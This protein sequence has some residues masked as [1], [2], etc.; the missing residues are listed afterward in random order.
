MCLGGLH[1]DENLLAPGP[2][3]FPGCSV[4]HVTYGPRHSTGPAGL[5]C[6]GPW[7][8]ELGGT[9]L[10][11]R[12][13]TGSLPSAPGPAPRKGAWLGAPSVP[14]SP[15]KLGAGR[16]DE[17]PCHPISLSPKSQQGPS[18]S[19]GGP[20]GQRRSSPS[21]TPGSGPSRACGDCGRNSV[22]RGGS[23]SRLQVRRGVCS[24]QRGRG[25][26]WHA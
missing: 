20:G 18:A 21:T 9:F 1:G 14:G 15:S 10:G 25:P 11:P 16:Q 6:Q 7:P 26:A 3:F 12:W 5:L 4:S 8:S 22:R 13:P 2:C 24:P 17:K 19:F 23:D